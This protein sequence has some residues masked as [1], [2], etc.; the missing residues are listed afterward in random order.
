MTQI[1]TDDI[2]EALDQANSDMAVESPE[3]DSKPQKSQKAGLTYDPGVTAL[4][5]P[6]GSVRAILALILT[7]GTIILT[8]IMMDFTM[9][10]EAQEIIDS[11]GFVHT[12]YSPVDVGIFIS[13]MS[14]LTG[15]YTLNAIVINAYFSSGQGTDIFKD[16]NKMIKASNGH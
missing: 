4:W 8:Y 15:L 6:A 12:T 7:L 3:S 1:N 9:S 11:K 16:I 10:I 13:G 14:G 5:M 2:N